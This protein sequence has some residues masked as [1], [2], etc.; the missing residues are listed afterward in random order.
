VELTKPNRG[1]APAEVS[2]HAGPDVQESLGCG[3][4]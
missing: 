4:P 2:A 3:A 1:A